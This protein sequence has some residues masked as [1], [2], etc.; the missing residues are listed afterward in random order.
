MRYYKTNIGFFG[1]GM[2]EQYLLDNRNDFIDFLTEEELND[3]MKELQEYSE[4][5][6]IIIEEITEKEYREN[7]F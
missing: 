4:P 1:C 5:Q 3:E 6:I 2:D 7:K